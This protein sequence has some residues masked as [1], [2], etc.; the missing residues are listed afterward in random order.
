TAR[1]SESR[2]RVEGR[3]RCRVAGRADDASVLDRDDGA[4]HARALRGGN[5]RPCAA[6]A[7]PA[8]EGPGALCAGLSPVARGHLTLARER[9]ELHRA[10]AARRVAPAGEARRP[11]VDAVRSHAMTAFEDW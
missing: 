1:P 3:T 11:V 6:V 8:R 10:C 4:A 9:H 5:R 2:S 7:A